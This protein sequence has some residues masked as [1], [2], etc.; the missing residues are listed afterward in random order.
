MIH[1]HHA[2]DARKANHGAA[3]AN[4]SRFPMFSVDHQGD[5][6]KRIEVEEMD[7]K[8]QAL[9]YA[10]LICYLVVTQFAG[11]GFFHLQPEHRGYWIAGAVLMLG[12]MFSRDRR[13]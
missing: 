7:L 13:R 5:G 4:S 11:L 2:P 1:T 8:D 10:A 3:R 9:G 12:A 6:K